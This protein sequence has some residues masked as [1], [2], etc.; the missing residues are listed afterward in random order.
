MAAI[1]HGAAPMVPELVFICCVPGTSLAF[2]RDTAGVGGL[3][4][5]RASRFLCAARRDALAMRITA[6]A[7]EIC[8]V[9]SV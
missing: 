5:R 6:D 1:G 2:S 3:R 8:L 4:R 9:R 7:P